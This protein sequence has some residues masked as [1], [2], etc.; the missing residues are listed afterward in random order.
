M[1]AVPKALSIDEVFL[2][3][4]LFCIALSALA[5]EKKANPWVPKVSL[6]EVEGG[7]LKFLAK[8]VRLFAATASVFS[9]PR[10]FP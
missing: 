9:D 8:M 2:P 4:N 10:R 5:K 7:V 3:A 6:P 1:T